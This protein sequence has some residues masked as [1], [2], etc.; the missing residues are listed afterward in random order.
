MGLIPKPSMAHHRYLRAL[1][2]ADDTDSWCST[3]LGQDY[4]PDDFSPSPF[5]EAVDMPVSAFIEMYKDGTPLCRWNYDRFGNP[6]GRDDRVE[7]PDG[8]VGL[9]NTSWAASY[10]YDAK[11]A[12]VGEFYFDSQ[13]TY[14]FWRLHSYA[15]NGLRIKTETFGLDAEFKADRSK[16]HGT[17]EII[18][19]ADE[20][21]FGWEIAERDGDAWRVLY[22][23]GPYL[24]SCERK[25]RGS[26]SFGTCA[27]P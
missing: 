16:L 19:V 6:T 13:E 11:G 24:V 15:E 4:D 17:I 21:L 9:L 2:S 20:R 5:V 25:E 7:F 10:E 22:D 14:G 3:L 23:N 12:L 18:P 1:F 8:S 27:N 26:D